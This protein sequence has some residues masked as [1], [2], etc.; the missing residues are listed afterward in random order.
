MVHCAIGMQEYGR[1][2]MR[3][4]SYLDST[5]VAKMMAHKQGK[6]IGAVTRY[7]G[8]G[9][10]LGLTPFRSVLFQLRAARLNSKSYWY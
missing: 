10:D 8:L 4:E 7:G 3:T 2:R 5:Q 9:I 6:V 1:Q